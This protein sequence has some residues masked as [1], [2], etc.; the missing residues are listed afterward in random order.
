MSQSPTTEPTRAEP[1]W[2]R[3]SSAMLFFAAI[4]VGGTVGAVRGTCYPAWS[5]TSNWHRIDN[6]FLGAT[7][8]LLVLGLL[9]HETALFVGVAFMLAIGAWGLLVEAPVAILFRILMPESVIA[10]CRTGL[11][12]L[13][14]YPTVRFFERQRV[15]MS[16]RD[17]V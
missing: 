13:F 12:I 9:R 3:R 16:E 6:A 17:T 11:G 8:A 4:L 2:L 14:A 7:I 15:E 10:I 5:E 1:H